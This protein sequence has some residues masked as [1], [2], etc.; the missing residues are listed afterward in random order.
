MP[1]LQSSAMY[2][3]TFFKKIHC[4]NPPQGIKVPG[5]P[6]P[7][8]QFFFIL[9]ILCSERQDFLSPFNTVNL[10][11]ATRSKGMKVLSCCTVGC[12]CVAFSTPTKIIPISHGP[13]RDDA[14]HPPS[15]PLQRKL[16]SSLKEEIKKASRGLLLCVHVPLLSS[17]AQLKFEQITA[18]ESYRTR[19]TSPANVPQSHI[20]FLTL[21]NELLYYA[22]D[23]IAFFSGKIGKMYVVVVVV[24]NP[25]SSSLEQHAQSLSF[26]PYNN[27]GH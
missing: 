8:K 9:W 25:I 26:S 1:L 13:I 21:G 11:L 3:E 14:K 15:H 2:M 10:S 27:T 17:S 4:V 22:E 23:V 24:L 16:D 6:V 19:L 12:V 18:I 5:S 20:H 7:Y